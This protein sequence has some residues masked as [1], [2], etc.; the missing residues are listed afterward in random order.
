MGLFDKKEKMT[1]DHASGVMF[2]LSMTLQDQAMIGKKGLGLDKKH[3]I[4][5]NTGYALGISMLFISSQISLKRV[6]EFIRS[7]MKN[8]E[9]TL[10]SDLKPIVPNIQKYCENAKNFVLMETNDIDS[11]VL[12]EELTKHYMQD[13]FGN[14]K[15]SNEI[16]DLAKNDLLFYFQKTQEFVNYIKIKN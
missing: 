6:N 13:L 10:N 7:S 8:A 5:V 4:A 12:F 9:I 16:F 2:V 11:N 1:F 14:K 3:I 15:Y